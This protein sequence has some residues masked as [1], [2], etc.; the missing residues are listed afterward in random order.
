[1]NLTIFDRGCFH[2]ISANDR[3]RYVMR[4][5]KIL[6]DNGILLKCFSDKE[7]RQEGQ[8]RFSQNGIKE[9]FEKEGGF[10]VEDIKETVYQD[11]LNPLPKALFVVMMKRANLKKLS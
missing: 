7:L 9:I 6:R 11:T 3:K 10:K 1:M 2:V 8:H 5:K 4:I